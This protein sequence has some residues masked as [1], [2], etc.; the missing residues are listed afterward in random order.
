[1]WLCLFLW[2]FIYSDVIHLKVDVQFHVVVPDFDHFVPTSDQV[3]PWLWDRQ[4]TT[5]T[6]MN[7]SNLQA[8]NISLLFM[9]MKY[10]T[11]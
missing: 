5:A 1:M 3:A 11:H 9:Y 2:I 7:I 10:T 6:A 8:N 4:T